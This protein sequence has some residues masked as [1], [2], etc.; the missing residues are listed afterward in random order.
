MRVRI[1]AELPH[2]R[3]SVVYSF[4]RVVPW[5]IPYPCSATEI[6]QVAYEIRLAPLLMKRCLI[7]GF[8][9]E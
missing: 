3:P 4:T 7:N 1:R 2:P 6:E 5:L 8:F 9:V